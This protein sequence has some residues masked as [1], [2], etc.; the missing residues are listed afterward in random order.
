MSLRSGT[1]YLVTHYR[2]IW[3]CYLSPPPSPSLSLFFVSQY[4]AQV[5]PVERV[6]LGLGRVATITPVYSYDLGRRPKPCDLCLLVRVAN[7]IRYCI[8]YVFVCCLLIIVLLLITCI[9]LASVTMT[10]NQAT[11]LC[12]MR[13][14]T[15]GIMGL[16]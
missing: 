15:L 4:Y 9:P 14:L 16:Q 1:Q 12:K 8:I 7:D 13:K 5:G 2:I 6:P 3:Y 10:S 11:S